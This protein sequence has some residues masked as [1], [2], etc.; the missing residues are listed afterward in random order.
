MTIKDIAKLADVLS[1][2]K[3]SEDKIVAAYLNQTRSDEGTEASD[4]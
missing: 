4:A 3:L 2:D 1:S